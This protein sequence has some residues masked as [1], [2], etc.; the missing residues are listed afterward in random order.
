MAGKPN[1]NPAVIGM[2]NAE[3][4]LDPNKFT[5]FNRDP[6]EI[7]ADQMRQLYAYLYPFMAADFVHRTAM[8]KW[9]TK[10]EEELEQKLD[11][12]Q[13][14]TTQWVKDNHDQH[15]HIGNNG[16]PTSPAFN[17]KPFAQ[18]PRLERWTSHIEDGKFNDGEIHI[19]IDFYGLFTRD[20]LDNTE[21]TT[22]YSI[23]DQLSGGDIILP[24][25]AGSDTAIDNQ[26]DFATS[27]GT[28]V[29]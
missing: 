25:D 1:D 19:T 5:A 28:G 27:L 21:V 11:K 14:D 17:V 9:E 26:T 29:I 7:T 20:L 18:P 6:F 12:F 3:L 23:E 8:S 15:Q 24:F 4:A 2:W 22:S 16:A 10:M 13:S